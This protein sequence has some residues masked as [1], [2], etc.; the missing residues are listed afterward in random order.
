MTYKDGNI[1]DG[2]HCCRQRWRSDN[3][4]TDLQAGAET[5]PRGYNFLSC[6]T[7]LSMEFEMHI[8]IK[9]LRNL[10]FSGS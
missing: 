10:A 8:S 3:R 7:Y 5:W 1:P 4:G 9:M 6:S 2:T